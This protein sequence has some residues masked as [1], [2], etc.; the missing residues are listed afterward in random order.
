MAYY[1]CM[2]IDR[3]ILEGFIEE[4][5]GLLKEME[6]TLESFEDDPQNL[7]YLETYGQ[8]IDRIM[9]AAKTIGQENIGTISELGK[10]IGYKASQNDDAKLN[11]VV[12][13]ILLDS[14]DLLGDIFDSLESP[15]SQKKYNIDAFIGRLEWLSEKFKHIERASVAFEKESPTNAKKARTTAELDAL[16]NQLK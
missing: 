4:G 3:E 10:I 14:V 13:G 2:D 9:G 1:E 7:Q 6:D 8:L 12:C 15:E 5:R 11:Q 16:I